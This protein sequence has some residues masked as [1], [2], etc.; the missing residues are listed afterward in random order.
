MSTSRRTQPRAPARNCSPGA[1]AGGQCG[2]GFGTGT[3]CLLGPRHPHSSHEAGPT[4][5]RQVRSAQHPHAQNNTSPPPPPR[6]P[7][8]RPPSPSCSRRPPTRT[9]LRA[10]AGQRPSALF[11]LSRRASP[12]DRHP[13]TSTGA[14]GPGRWCRGPN[15]GSVCVGGSFRPRPTGARTRVLQLGW[16]RMARPPPPEV[17]APPAAGA[18]RGGLCPTLAPRAPGIRAGGARDR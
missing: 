13:Q 6:S 4:L 1:P 14:V 15:P 5:G 10:Q 17:W 9:D 11:L 8:E 16:R 2:E 18:S 7:Q 3:R 12:A